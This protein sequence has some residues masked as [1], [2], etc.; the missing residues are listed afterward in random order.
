M[1]R[2]LVKTDCRCCNSRPECFVQRTKNEEE[3]YTRKEK[4]F[5][6]VYLLIQETVF[7]LNFLT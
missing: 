4:K 3:F 7:N 2:Y 1:D 5:S 6:P